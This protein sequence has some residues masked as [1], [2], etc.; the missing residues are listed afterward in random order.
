MTEQTEE[1]AKIDRA[2]RKG[3][4]TYKQ[5]QRGIAIRIQRNKARHER[6]IAEAAPAM[7]AALKNFV[8]A[9]SGA[10]ICACSSEARRL[11]CAYCIARAAIA[12]AEGE[13]P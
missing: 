12:A 5:L 9:P 4:A 2:W 11:P 1:L 10:I 8:T 13:T 7:L 6:A 3:K